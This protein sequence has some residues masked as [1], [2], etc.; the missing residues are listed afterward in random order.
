MAT[1]A[2]WEATVENWHHPANI[3][4]TQIL[5]SF[6]YHDTPTHVNYHFDKRWT[7]I[8]WFSFF[9]ELLQIEL[10]WSVE[11]SSDLSWGGSVAKSIKW[12]FRAAKNPPSSGFWNIYR[13]GQNFVGPNPRGNYQAIKGEGDRVIFP[14]S[15]QSTIILRIHSS[16]GCKRVFLR[17]MF[18]AAVL[19]R[20]V[21][22]VEKLSNKM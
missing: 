5:I 7:N 12:Y 20:K 3:I 9:S 15:V 18:L 10:V 6:K 11:A 16:S 19:I 2:S 4:F 22:K 14:L 1:E 21:V 8:V 17:L 13:V